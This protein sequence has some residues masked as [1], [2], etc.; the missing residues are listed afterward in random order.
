M[1]TE[2]KNSKQKHRK[3]ALIFLIYSNGCCYNLKYNFLFV[4]IIIFQRLIFLA[5][6][7]ITRKLF[8]F[9]PSIC[10]FTWE[11]HHL[12]NSAC[13]FPWLFMLMLLEC[14]KLIMSIASFTYGGYISIQRCVGLPFNLQGELLQPLW[15]RV[16]LNIYAEIYCWILLSLPAIFSFFV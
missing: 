14:H 2:N 5:S 1:K 15:S 12:E 10:M 11:H 13:Y 7:Q 9:L 16:I 4:V 8:G 3:W 6:S